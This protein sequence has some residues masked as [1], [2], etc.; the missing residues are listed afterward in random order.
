MFIANSQYNVNRLAEK[1]QM[2]S[3]TTYLTHFS[4]LLAW[5]S[6]RAAYDMLEVDLKSKVGW[7]FAKS[8]QVVLVPSRRLQVDL[9]SIWDQV[10]SDWH[11]K[12]TP[13]SR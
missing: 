5:Q 7:F 9:G 4:C 10:G 8:N 2:Y 11:T 3:T 6:Y 12:V 13:T 1:K